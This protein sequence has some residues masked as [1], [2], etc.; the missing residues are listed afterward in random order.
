[1]HGTAA[2]SERTTP[3]SQGGF[4]RLPIKS[5]ADLVPALVHT[6]QDWMLI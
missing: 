6:S 4:M 1:V 5:H 2:F 3:S